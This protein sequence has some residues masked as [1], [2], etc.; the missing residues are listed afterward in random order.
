VELVTD[1][2]A[3]A[4]LVAIPLRLLW[5]VNLPRSQ[6]ILLFSIFSASILVTIVSVVHA[7]YLLGPSGLLEGLTANVECAVSLIVANLAVVVTHIYRLIRNGEDIDHA[8]YDNSA[9]NAGRMGI[10]GLRRFLGRAGFKTQVSSMR[11]A[12]VIPQTHRNP[13]TKSGGETT[14]GTETQQASKTYHPLSFVTDMSDERDRDEKRGD[15]MVAWSR[16]NMETSIL[17]SNTQATTVV[18]SPAQAHV[19]T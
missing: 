15:N 7:A 19:Q 10:G 1:F 6:R 11:F 13:D 14:T 2:I 12:T 18:S 5:G 17:R 16:N 9:I 8:S 4:I 3:D